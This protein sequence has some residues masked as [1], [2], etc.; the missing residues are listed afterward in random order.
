MKPFYVALTYIITKSSNVFCCFDFTAGTEKSWHRVIQA[1][2]NKKWKQSKDNGLR[3][4]QWYKLTSLEYLP[5][6]ERLLVDRR[7]RNSWNTTGESHNEN[8]R[9]REIITRSA[10]RMSGGRFQSPLNGPGGHV[11]RQWYN[12]NVCDL[13]PPAPIVQRQCLRPLTSC[14]WFAC[15]LWPHPIITWKVV[16]IWLRFSWRQSTARDT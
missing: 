14:I 6:P 3:A 13:W 16:I 8:I 15:D 5:A 12:A 2:L 10:S 4:C 11:M 9:E 7:A 1:K